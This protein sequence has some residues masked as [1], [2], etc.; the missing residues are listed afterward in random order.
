ML[1]G[2]LGS[3]CFFGDTEVL[4]VE[5]SVSLPSLNASKPTAL[6]EVCRRPT[7]CSL[8][9]VFMGGGAHGAAVEPALLP[10]E[11]ACIE[12]AVTQEGVQGDV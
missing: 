2:D 8:R 1:L 3:L 11:G 10:E 12:A 7:S 9:G 5:P 6:R 4:C